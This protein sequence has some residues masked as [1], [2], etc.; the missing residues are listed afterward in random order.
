MTVSQYHGDPVTARPNH[1]CR[2]GTVVNSS[3]RLDVDRGSRV[4]EQ[5]MPDDTGGFSVHR[6]GTVME[7]R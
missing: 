7:L 5:I 4:D 1:N 6:H 3:G 2:N